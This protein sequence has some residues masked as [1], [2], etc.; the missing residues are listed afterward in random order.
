MF[1]WENS[2]HVSGID[3]LRKKETE[4]YKNVAAIPSFSFSANEY[5]TLAQFI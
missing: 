1:L 4:Y 5:V 3:L 2:A